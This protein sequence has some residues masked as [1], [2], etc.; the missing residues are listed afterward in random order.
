MTWQSA[1]DFWS[2]LYLSLIHISQDVKAVV[3]ACNTA[4]AY[5]LEEIKQELDIPIIG[6]VKPGA[7]VACSVTRNKKIGVIGTE[8][9]VSSQVYTRYINKQDPVSYTHL[10][11][12]KRQPQDKGAVFQ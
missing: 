7:R 6:V 1:K 5:A 10:D 9:T 2:I 3:V 8:A 4:S 12:Y 11:V